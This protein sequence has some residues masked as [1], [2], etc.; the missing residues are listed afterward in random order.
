MRRQAADG[1]DWVSFAIEDTGIGMTPE[2]LGR[3]FQRF[4]QGDETTTRRFGG[5]GL[6]LALSLAFARLM[7]GDIVVESR[8]GHGTT[9]TLRLPAALPE[10]S[11]AETAA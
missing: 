1:L 5:T 8:E 6:G 7:G 3:L 10:R 2:Q 9:F 11:E 4:S